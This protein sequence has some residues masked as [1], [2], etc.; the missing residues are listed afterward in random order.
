MDLQGARE[1]SLASEHALWITF[2][3]GAGSPWRPKKTHQ[4]RFRGR[5]LGVNPKIGG[6]PP[7][8]MVYF[9]EN[10]YEQVDDLGVPLF[11]ETPT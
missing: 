6:K 3:L 1:N 8:W 11:L 5:Y 2:Y 9:M 7:K 4:Q 10:P